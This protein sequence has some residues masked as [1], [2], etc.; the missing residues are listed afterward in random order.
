MKTKLK[1]FV[2]I[3]KTPSPLTYTIRDGYLFAPSLGFDL[4]DKSKNFQHIPYHLYF[5]S[6]E[7]IK[8]GEYAIGPDNVVILCNNSNYL[9]IQEHWCKIVA[10][11]NTDIPV[12]KIPLDFVEQYVKEKGRITSVEIEYEDDKPKILNG[13]VL[14]SVVHYF[15]SVKRD[16]STKE[17]TYT[18]EEARQLAYEVYISAFNDIYE[19]LKK[20]D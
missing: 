12:G 1:V 13:V 2:N 6:K 10:S 11:T 9:S 20:K 3:S 17:I 4:F 19:S 14:V 15:D 8:V 18:E 16:K 7:E 5:L